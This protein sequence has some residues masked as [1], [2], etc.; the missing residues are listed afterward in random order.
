MVLKRAFDEFQ[1]REPQTA[2]RLWS[3]GPMTVEAWSTHPTTDLFDYIHIT[4]LCL[5]R[6][7]T[8]LGSL[9]QG[10]MLAITIGFSLAIANGLWGLAAPSGRTLE[11]WA[12]D[13]L[14]FSNGGVA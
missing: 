7:M 13:A 4:N 3:G 10:M 2:I 12:S 8:V 9:G 1:W 6:F 11:Q 14:G 5:D